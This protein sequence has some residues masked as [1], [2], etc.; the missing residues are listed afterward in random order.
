VIGDDVKGRHGRRRNKDW[1]QKKEKQSETENNSAD[2]KAEKF[3]VVEQKAL[4]DVEKQAQKGKDRF[5]QKR[6][7]EGQ[8]ENQKPN[9][10]VKKDEEKPVKKGWW[11]RLVN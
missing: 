10:E 4:S 5:Q 9:D 11:N 3:K 8:N 6:R 1:K 2:N 7:K